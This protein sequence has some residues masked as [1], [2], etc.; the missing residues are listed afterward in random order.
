MYI[1]RVQQSTSSG[2]GT[3]QRASARADTTPQVPTATYVCVAMCI[4]QPPNVSVTVYMW[5]RTQTKARRNSAYLYLTP[6]PLLFASKRATTQTK[7]CGL[8]LRL[9]R[10]CC[11][12]RSH[13]RS[14]AAD[15]GTLPPSLACSAP[16]SFPKQQHV[17]S[18]NVAFRFPAELFLGDNITRPRGRN[19]RATARAHAASIHNDVRAWWHVHP[20][21][22]RL[23]VMF[24]I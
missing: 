2:K 6:K 18:L 5:L 24:C 11:A 19:P 10:R 20:A 7:G 1:L 23:R 14:S 8:A 15:C 22:K 4:L 3:T 17:H 12:A 13:H 16:F 21:A 9:C